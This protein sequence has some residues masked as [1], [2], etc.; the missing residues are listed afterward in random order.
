MGGLTRAGQ[1]G[2]LEVQTNTPFPY[3]NNH[4]SPASQ[5]AERGTWVLQ[6]FT[7]NVRHAERHGGDL[8]EP[9]VK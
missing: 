4:Y 1:A 6:G 2:I 3:M 7:S 9:S 8:G 5:L